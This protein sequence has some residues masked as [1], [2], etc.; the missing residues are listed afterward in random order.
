MK[1]FPGIIALSIAVAAAT[2]CS[3]NDCYENHS[4][5]PL[6]DFYSTET[7]GK[8]S[9]NDLEIYGIGAPGDSIL[10][11]QTLSQA[12]LP[13]R[14]WQDTTTYVFAYMSF[15]EEEEPDDPENP[16]NPDNT[17]SPDNSENSDDSEV[18]KPLLVPRMRTGAN[19]DFVPRDTVTFI[20]DRLPWY[21]S[22]G[23][24]AMYFF[25]MKEV[26]HTSHLIDSIYVEPRITNLNASNI[27][28][29]F[30]SDVNG[31]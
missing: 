6:A 7:M 8:V 14:V 9:V 19:T 1:R 30:K 21:V 16:E 5:M 10:Y 15:L 22:P 31:Y 20:Y 3:N 12:Y 24:G 26:R 4:A 18:S 25:E 17:D 29:F 13:F 27:K 23:C 28:I 11:H 2:G